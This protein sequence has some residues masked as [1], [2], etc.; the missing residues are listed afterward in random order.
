MEPM[1]DIAGLASAITGAVLIGG[2]ALLGSLIDRAYDGTVL[3]LAL[4]FVAGALIVSMLVRAS[5]RPVPSDL[6]G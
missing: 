5:E 4:A 2:G 3:P 6:R 1:G